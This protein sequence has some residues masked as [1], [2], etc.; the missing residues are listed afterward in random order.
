MNEDFGIANQTKLPGK[1]K[2]AVPH[3]YGDYVR[4]LFVAIAILSVLVIPLWGNLLPFGTFFELGAAV[5]LVVLAG[6]T[7]PHSRT[8]ALINVLVAGAGAFLLEMAA[9]EF[10]GSQSFALFLARESA[11]IL[12]LLAL[13]FAVK[14]MRAM[15]L[16]QVG[17][18][19][20]KDEF[21]G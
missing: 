4:K 13:Y 6:L 11:T 1:L 16:K 17:H 7:N 20:K 21:L 10:Y 14:T 8:V 12:F 18:E 15:F 3:Y 9:I 5:F 2:K 19:A